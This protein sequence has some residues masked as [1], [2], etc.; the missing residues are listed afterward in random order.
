MAA[1]TTIERVVRLIP[2]YDTELIPDIQPFI[3]DASV[4]VDEIIAIDPRATAASMEMTE[5][6]LSAHLVCITDRQTN[7]E[8]VKSILVTYQ[9]L[10]RPGLELTHYG[11]Q[12]M[13]LDTTGRLAG[14]NA[15]TNDGGGPKQ[16]FWAGIECPG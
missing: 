4:L 14:W 16:F 2:D 10:L 8:Q 15:R 1:R 3:D 7:T 6:Y 11:A 12:A 5:R 13:R 9:S